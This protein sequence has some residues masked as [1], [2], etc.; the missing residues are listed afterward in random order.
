MM[1]EQSPT[2]V[3]VQKKLKASIQFIIGAVKV[4]GTDFTVFKPS[5]DFDEA[6]SF[7]E[8][9][10]EEMIVENSQQ[11]HRIWKIIKAMG[12]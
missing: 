3:D 8:N 7:I 11:K 10:A 9:W 4:D 1:Q 6:I 5:D 12:I 2:D